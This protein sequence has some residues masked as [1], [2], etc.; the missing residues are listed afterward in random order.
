[1]SRKTGGGYFEVG[2][3]KP[4]IGTRWPPGQ[5][6]DP[7]GRPKKDKSLREGLLEVLRRKTPAQE[8]GRQRTRPLWEIIVTN[9]AT[10]AARHDQ[11]AMRNLVTVMRFLGLGAE[12]A[13]PS[14]DRDKMS[15]EDEAILKAY[16]EQALS[17]FK[18]QTEDAE[19][20]AK[21]EGALNDRADKE[22]K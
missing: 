12:E 6:G 11:V 20:Q 18:N 21:D 13:A 9:L 17:E 19:T 3:D 8:N 1:M 22:D 14:A 10:D 5:S 15:K 4:P 16:L 7:R 2:R